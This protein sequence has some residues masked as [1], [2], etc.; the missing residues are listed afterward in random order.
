MELKGGK[1]GSTA[2][3]N[4]SASQRRVP[5]ALEDQDSFENL[6]P[7]SSGRQMPPHEPAKLSNVY[8]PSGDNITVSTT[9]QAGSNRPQSAKAQ[10]QGLKKNWK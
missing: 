10:V 8:S 3:L 4:R 1:K 5:P 6:I 2:S 9:L 7:S